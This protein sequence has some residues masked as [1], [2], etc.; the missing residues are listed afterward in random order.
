MTKKMQQGNREL[1]SDVDLKDFATGTCQWN[2]EQLAWA[3]YETCQAALQN[4]EAGY[5]MKSD[6]RDTRDL[7]RKLALDQ[8]SG[9][10]DGFDVAP[11]GSGKWWRIR[12]KNG[13][14]IVVCEERITAEIIN[15]ECAQ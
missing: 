1:F 13:S 8:L 12:L 14:V 2:N 4:D 6:D 9:E 5:F 7:M 11:D 10:W 15:G 3:V